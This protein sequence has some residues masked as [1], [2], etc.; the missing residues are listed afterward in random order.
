MPVVI[1][2]DLVLND[3]IEPPLSYPRILWHDIWRDATITASSEQEEFPAQ[4]VADGLTWDSWKATTLPAWIEVTLAE[5]EDI[6][7]ALLLHTLGSNEAIVTVQYHDGAEWVDIAEVAP[8]SDRML[9]FLFEP[10]FASRFRF[11]IAGENSPEQIPA[12]KVAM[13]GRALAMQRGVTLDHAPI[14][15]SR[16]T[17]ARPQISEGG[18]L[19][20]RSI[21][22]EGVA[23]TIR[24]E[25]LTANWVRRHFE[26]FMEAA[27]TR[28]F[29][30]IW[31]HEDYPAEVAYVWTPSGKEDI[32]PQHAGLPDR[33]N[34][35]FEVEGVIE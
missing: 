18:Q 28:P 35:E 34:V 11:F 33:M 6:D 25:N 22:R 27:R 26:P 3:T 20:G 30:W 21:L 10:V 12:I 15:L 32:R 1:S 24:V 9:A 16:R 14:T 13:M 2:S 31:H 17:V 8:A 5:A 19:L 7:Y 23:T 29:G 4:N